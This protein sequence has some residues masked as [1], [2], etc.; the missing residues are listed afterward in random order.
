M[1]P[2]A[3][4]IRSISATAAAASS[5]WAR[6]PSPGRATVVAGFLERATGSK[7]DARGVDLYARLFRRREHVAGA[8]AMMANWDLA[9][10]AADF[11]RVNAPVQLIYGDRDAAIPPSV[12]AEVAKRITGSTTL[13]LPG[14]GHL[15]HE[16][17]PAAAIRII[18]DVMAERD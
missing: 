3:A 14:L 6:W 7:I 13:A 17:D 9:A 12:A 1:I 11:G 8:L 5:S 4:A 10:L 18:R 15:A 2:H 16:E